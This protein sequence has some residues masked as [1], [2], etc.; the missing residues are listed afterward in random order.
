[1]GKPR[2]QHRCGWKGRGGKEEEKEKK[3]EKKQ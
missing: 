3:E 2:T 1:M